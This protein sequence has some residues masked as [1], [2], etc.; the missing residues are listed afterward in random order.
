VLIGYKP[1]PLPTTKEINMKVTTI[2]QYSNT[3]YVSF[4][5][6]G[7]Q[8]NESEK[9]ITSNTE[10]TAKWLAHDDFIVDTNKYRSILSNPKFEECRFEIQSSRYISP[11]DS[12]NYRIYTIKVR[13]VWQYEKE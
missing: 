3:Y 4:G 13:V 10:R 2:K 12:P 9:T 7:A 1:Y 8:F 5:Y 11:N 6:N